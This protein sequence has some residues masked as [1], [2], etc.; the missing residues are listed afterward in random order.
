[1]INDH[2]SLPFLTTQFTPHTFSSSIKSNRSTL[3]SNIRLFIL[4]N[5]FSLVQVRE[6]LFIK[7]FH[8]LLLMIVKT[9]VVIWLTLEFRNF[10]SDL[11]AVR[12]V[13]DDASRS[14]NS[15]HEPHYSS[16]CA[17]A[18]RKVEQVCLSR[19]FGVP[20]STQRGN[21]RPLAD[22]IGTTKVL[23]FGRVT[24]SLLLFSLSF[25]FLSFS[26]SLWFSSPSF[27]AHIR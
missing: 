4:Y 13:D 20:S 9:P 18:S 16:H 19:I 5:F 8:I 7:A 14:S 23:P 2:N 6:I 24:G 27:S 26:R 3:K 1:M 12:H 21:P 10:L 25:S 11:L 22:P 15:S 17:F